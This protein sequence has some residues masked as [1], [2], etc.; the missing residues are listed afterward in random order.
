VFGNLG[1]ADENP[2]PFRWAANIGVG[3]ASP[4]R[5]RKLDTFGVGSFYVGLN[6]SLRTFAPRLVP[7]DD[8]QGVELFYN[9]GL[10]PWCH[11]TPDLQV[12]IPARERVDTAVVF[13]VRAKVD[14]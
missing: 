7:L 6:D 12:V 10:T 14:F 9:I 2:S 13:G 3:G 4:L 1:I 11:V 8:E 5:C